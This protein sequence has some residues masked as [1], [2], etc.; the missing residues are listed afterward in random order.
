MNNATYCKLCGKMI[1]F[2]T[3]AKGGKSMPC[4]SMRV[5]YAPDPDAK[6]T[7]YDGSGEVVRGFIMSAP[8]EGTLKAYRPHWHTCPYASTH[9][10]N[11]KPAIPKQ[12][13]ADKPGHPDGQMSFYEGPYE[14]ARAEA[15]A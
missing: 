11:K 6:G 3:T 7:L 8:G 2:I 10:R 4:D 5:D 9:R 13:P 12:P 15:W 1:V 14:E